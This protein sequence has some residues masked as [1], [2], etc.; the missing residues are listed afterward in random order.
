MSNPTSRPDLRQFD[1]QDRAW[2]AALAGLEPSD[3]NSVSTGDAAEMSTLNAQG[4]R[5]LRQ[6]FAQCDEIEAAS[7]PDEQSQARML[8]KLHRAGVLRSVADD[9]N[10]QRP[11]KTHGVAQLLSTLINWLLPSGQGASVRYALV[12]GVALSVM[13]VP[14]VTQQ[15]HQ[16]TDDALRSTNRNASLAKASQIVL[17]DNP[18]Q[19]AQQLLAA[20]QSAGVM[21]EVQAQAEGFG[22]RVTVAPAQQGAAQQAIARWGLTVPAQSALSVSVLPTGRP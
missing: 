1:P 4:A 9:I 14:V 20:L 6:Y 8:A 21:A 15:G 17:S 5:Q 18:E 12:A 13:V 11:G 22:L 10:R 16:Q 2:L 7:A 19:T 3:L